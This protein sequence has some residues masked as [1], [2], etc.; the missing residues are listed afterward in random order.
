MAI[1]WTKVVEQLQAEL[2]AGQVS[3]KTKVGVQG[4][5]KTFRD[6]RD[7]ASLETIER[8]RDANNE[9]DENGIMSLAEIDFNL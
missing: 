1:D 5:S 9:R 6:F 2:E 3:V 4:G 7:I 8:N